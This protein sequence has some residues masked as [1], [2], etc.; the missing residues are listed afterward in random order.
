MYNYYGLRASQINSVFYGCLPC[1]CWDDDDKVYKVP[2]YDVRITY[3]S[4]IYGSRGRLIREITVECDCC[5][6]SR[7]FN[8]ESYDVYQNDL[9]W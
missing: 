2:R 8:V 5:G 9:S 6:A 3:G 7:R 1:S 4:T